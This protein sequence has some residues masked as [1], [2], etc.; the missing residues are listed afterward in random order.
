MIVAVFTA[1]ALSTD[2]A[3]I[4]F[5][6][7]KLM[8]TLVFIA[9][10][11]FGI[12]LG[13]AVAVP[14]W[15]VYGLVNPNGVDDPIT[16]SFLI[17]GECFYAVGGAILRRTSIGEEIFSMRPKDQAL[18]V[19]EEDDIFR[20]FARRIRKLNLTPSLVFALVGLQ[21]TFGY[22]LI[23]NFASW[24]FLTSSLY[25]ALIVG[26]IVGVPFSVTHEGSNAIFF[27]TVAPAVI[28]ATKRM[29]LGFRRGSAE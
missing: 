7:I 6:N 11:L 1:L 15:L 21:T 27:A 5:Q 10:F 23:T 22:D 16:L 17:L 13:V 12:R 14:T 20:R 19:T 26:N 28:V 3:L 8:D 4:G 2:Y 25:Q 9:A 29:G 24:L 18:L